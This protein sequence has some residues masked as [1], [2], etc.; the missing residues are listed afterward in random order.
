MAESY[1]V[2]VA[3]V[4]QSDLV[5]GWGAPRSGGRKHKGLDIFAPKGTPA[6]AAVQ[7]T[8]VK[9]GDSGGLGGKRVWIKDANGRYYYYA[10]LDSINVE[11]GQTL[12]Q[13]QQLG[14]VGQTGNARTTPPHLHF[15]INSSPNGEDGK[16]NPFDVLTGAKSVP[17]DMENIP[18]DKNVIA[19]GQGVHEHEGFVQERTPNPGDLL[20]RVFDSIS[21]QIAG[22]ERSHPD[23]FTNLGV[24][25]SDN[26]EE[27]EEDN[28]ADESNPET[29]GLIE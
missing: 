15:S 22:G 2:P 11:V 13:G 12:A 17:S 16:I 9:A 29:G 8:V 24:A 5:D 7:G 23:Q 25:D 18:T 21:K 4:R 10:H 27:E 14:T 6:V 1:I 20:S 28:I 26:F 19:A 3:G